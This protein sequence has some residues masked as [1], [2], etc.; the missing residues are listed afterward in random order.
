[1]EGRKHM[2]GLTW[3]PWQDGDTGLFHAART[4]GGRTKVFVFGNLGFQDRADCV[5]YIAQAD[6]D[7]LNR[8]ATREINYSAG[9]GRVLT[10]DIIAEAERDDGPPDDPRFE[11]VETTT[12]AGETRW[13]RGRCHHLTP[14]PVDLITGELVAWWCPDCGEQFPANRWPCPEH[15]WLPLPEVSHMPGLKPGLLTPG[16][17]WYERW[18]YGNAAPDTVDVHA[19]PDLTG[20]DDAFRKSMADGR[21]VILSDGMRVTFVGPRKPVAVRAATKVADVTGSAWAAAKAHAALILW[22][23]TCVVMGFLIPNIIYFIAGVF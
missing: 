18:V 17:D 23:V 21:H 7:E 9:P 5:A 20:F 11:W 6:P 15:L 22:L 19:D 8:L 3:V 10:R 14:A 2:S 13:T 1:M 12:F 16:S 4:E